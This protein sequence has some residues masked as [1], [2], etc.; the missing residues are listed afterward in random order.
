MKR[1]FLQLVIVFAIAP[2][3][4]GPG[5]SVAA[6]LA[7]EAKRGNLE[8]VR[9]LIAAGVD[10]D[11]RGRGGNTAIYLAAQKGH[12][13]VVRALAEAGADVDV[14]NDFGSTP[15]HVAARAGHVDVIRVL[16]EFGADLDVLNLSGGS[17]SGLRGGSDFALNRR[18]LKPSTPLSKAARA[19]Q[20]EA[21]KALIE[22]GAKLPAPDA[23][24]EA[25]LRG[26][27]EIAAYITRATAER[28]KAKKGPSKALASSANPIELTSDYGRKI[29]VVIGISRYARLNDLEGA[30]RDAR[31]MAELLR[32]LGFDTVHELYDEDATRVR[33]L[34]LV[35]QKLRE[36]TS[37]NDLAFI[38]FAGHGATETLPNGEKR[39]YLIPTE[40]SAQDPYVT[41]IS[42][43]TIRD[44][45][46]RLEA[47]HVYYAVDACYSGG[48]ATTAAAGEAT[49]G[50]S[51]NSSVQVLTAGLEGQQ[52]IEEGGRGVFT[53]YL[54]QGLRGEANLNG[55][56]VISASE[57]GWFV[58]NQVEQATGGRQTPA[59]GRLGGTGE[60]T[61]RL[62]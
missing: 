25:S 10:L 35:G 15:L 60:V 55:D 6:S 24:R 51:R 8:K 31:E 42:M 43:E 3:C 30:H 37:K 26:H 44:L 41:G 11:A 39:G 27:D 19:G 20:F 21:V 9:E 1:P 29:A 47:R 2:I 56:D 7:R 16:A 38:F 54:I 58:A 34:E 17:A 61:F 57:I 23:A 50:D 32:T 5:I 18:A 36:E 12:A 45:S 53:S 22:L 52:A 48:L 4:L 40:G 13:D 33:I 46:N 59:Y 14:D 49:R 28:R 62:H